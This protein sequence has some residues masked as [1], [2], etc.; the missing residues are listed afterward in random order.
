MTTIELLESLRDLDINLWVEEGQLRFK[1]PRGALS[2]PIRNRIKKRK[3]EIISFLEETQSLVQRERLAITPVPR[4]QDLPLSFTQQRLW[5]LDQLQPG[6]VTYNLPV[7]VRLR[8]NL[9]IDALTQSLQ[10]LCRRHEALRTTFPIRDGA[11]VQSIAERSEIQLRIVDEDAGRGA[12]RNGDLHQLVSKLASEPFDLQQ[13]PLFR[14]ALIRIG[15]DEHALLLTMHHIIGDGVSVGILL[16]EL[17]ALYKGISSGEP[18]ALPQQSIQYADYAAWQR[19]P[20]HQGVLDQ[21]LAYWTSKLGDVPTVL[22]IPTDRSRNDVQTSRGA[23]E[24]LLLE[25]RLAEAVRRVSRDEQV[26]PFMLILAAFKVLLA[27]YGGTRDISVGTPIAGRNRSELEN[28]VGCFLNTLVLRTSLEGDPSFSDLLAR[29]KETSLGA[30]ANQDLPFE[31]LVLEINPD[32]DTSQSPLFQVMFVFQNAAPEEFSAQLPDLALSR[33]GVERNTANFDLTLVALDD[34]QDVRLSFEYN[35]DLFDGESVQ[36]MLHQLEHLLASV[37]DDPSQRFSQLPWMSAADR[38]ELVVRW[39]DTGDQASDESC[40][41]E[42]FCEQVQLIPHAIAVVDGSEAISYSELNRR[43]NQLAHMLIDMEIGHESIVGIACDRSIEMVVALLGVLKAGAA[44]LPLDLNYPEA[45]LT[46]MIRDAGVSVILA[47]TGTHETLSSIQSN[48]NE[49]PLSVFDL[50]A[51]WDEVARFRST[52][53]A[54]AVDPRSLAYVIYTSGSTGRPKGVM[55]EHESVVNHTWAVRTLFSLHASDRVLQFATLNFDAAVE[56]IFPTLSTGASL[57]LRPGESFLSVAEL[58][59]TIEREQLTFVDLPTVFW[60]QWTNELRDGGRSLPTLRLVVL[61]GD[62]AEKDAILRW[63]ST[64]GNRI[65]IVNTYGPT[66]A[67]IIS[68]AYDCRPILEA[69]EPSHTEIPIGSP[70]RNASNLVL[71]P[72]L[73]LSPFRSNGELHIGGLP[74]ARGYIRRPD[75]TA[76]RFIPDNFGERNGAR[77]YRSGDL[78]RYRRDGN[79]EFVGRVD[80]QLKIRGFRVE[81]G[82]I[83]REILQHPEVQEA[84]VVARANASLGKRLAAYYVTGNSSLS[85]EELRQFLQARIAQY[86]LPAVFVPCDSLPRTLSGKIDR[87]ALPDPPAGELPQS[88]VAIPTSPMEETLVEIWR[89]LLGIDSI[90]I[91][92]NFFTLGGDSIIAIQLISRARDR[93]LELM[94]IQLFQ[95][96]TIAELAQAVEES[97]AQPIEAE[98]T[99]VSGSVPLTPIQ[100]WFF[101]A[102]LVNPHHWNQSVLL[103]VPHDVNTEAL[104]RA[105]HHLRDHHDALR[106]RYRPTGDGWTQLNLADDPTDCFVEV[107]LAETSSTEHSAMIEAVASSIQSSLDLQEGPLFRLAHFNLGNSPGRLMLVAHHLVVDG[108]AWRVLLEDLQ[109]LY[110]Q[111]AQN[112]AISLPRKTTSF[113]YWANRIREYAQTDQARSEVEYWLGSSKSAIAPLPVD[114]VGDNVE[115]SATTVV[116]QLDV[117]ETRALLQDVPAAYHTEINDLLLTSLA[118]ALSRW[119]GKRAFLVELEGHGREP[120]FEE[121]D[122]SRTVG[123][124]TT[125]FPVPI[126]LGRTVEPG[127]SLVSVKEQLRQIPHRGIGFG[128]LKYFGDHALKDRLAKLPKAEISFNYLG[129]LDQHAPSESEFGVAMERRGGEQDP[130]EVR[131]SL[132]DVIASVRGERLQVRLRYSCNLYRQETIQALSEWYFDELRALIHHCSGS[133]TSHT[134]SDF[135]LANINQDQLSK[136][137]SQLKPAK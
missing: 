111:V 55:V 74:V 128:F 15:A 6:D 122:L 137:L 87:R 66:E 35:C 77:L 67:T 44:Y 107:D 41:H 7:A 53:P 75:V 43:A 9:D 105:A 60:H 25:S 117:E 65:R 49:Q 12:S 118:L 102:G 42:L 89:D 79:L 31:Q 80:H 108:V 70:I 63:R 96:Q 22:E 110:A 13:G 129:Q 10:E 32:R 100:Q 136:V 104:R 47:S 92:D 38:H 29:V 14:P 16:R 50:A 130:N 119:T 21:Q 18:F 126:D 37:A 11:A 33:I 115:S 24:T 23:V 123:W 39:N 83:E 3:Q 4:D 8:G 132:L 1:A 103:S 106:M 84:V 62:K 81:P 99:T 93:G 76:D 85:P 125:T 114:R 64:F 113:Q 78:V 48:A 46:F 34:E 98:Q 59:E 133:D 68:T 26:T 5:F 57:V 135:E 61:G 131:D 19:D 120:L 112:Y 127:E 27:Q 73:A 36:N 69:A 82:A 58:E 86:M 124:F 90:G 2:D 95:H 17:T 109:A 91:N 71:T 45:Q 28:M 51:R 72:E 52:N 134:A 20:R 88:E 101:A 40:I 56:E 116:G 30:F 94:P 54:V 97:D 121:V